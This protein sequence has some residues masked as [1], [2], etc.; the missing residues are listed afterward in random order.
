[1]ENLYNLKLNE[2]IK[3]QFDC[4]CGKTHAVN[5]EIDYGGFDVLLSVLKKLKATGQIVFIS[6]RSTFFEYGETIL[7]LI[8]QAGATPLNI[9][10]NKKFDNTLENI[11][12]LFALSGEVSAVVVLDPYLFGVASYFVSIRNL[13]LISM[14]L[15]PDADDVLSP[16][17]SITFKGKKEKVTSAG[18][19]HVI[20]NTELLSKAPKE[21]SAIAFA[22]LASGIISLIDYRMRGTVGGEKLCKNSY[23]LV[24]SCI[25]GTINIL[26]NKTQNIPVFLIENRIKLVIADIY[27]DGAILSGSGESCVATLLEPS[28]KEHYSF[29]ER[30]LY[31]AY[32]LIDLYNIFFKYPHSNLLYV[33]DLVERAEGYSRLTGTN[34]YETLKDINKRALSAKEI[35]KKLNLVNQKF[36]DETQKL[37]SM[38]DKLFSAYLSLGGKEDLLENYTPDEI[39]RAVYY[40]P[41]TEGCFS[42]LTLMRDTGILELLKI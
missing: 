39:R 12:G 23:D 35:D 34:E 3:L 14:P 21:S 27:T 37:V 36:L 20:I 10:L 30:K 40:A 28:G 17:A 19:R 1:M 25:S 6:S 33:P 2:L 8:S 41:D 24:R 32:K 18:Y 15:T 7:D 38:K 9:I 31:S 11:S 5:A 22:S 29:S 42:V 4:D 16:T 26:K 13:H